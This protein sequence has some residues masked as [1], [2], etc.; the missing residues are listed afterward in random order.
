MIF[1]H[2]N[3]VRPAYYLRRWRYFE[4]NIQELEDKELENAKVL[5]HSLRSLERKYLTIL[6][7]VYYF[8]EQN[9][10]PSALPEK[11]GVS[12]YKFGNMRREAQDELKKE[13]R[14]TI[15]LMGETHRR[16]IHKGRH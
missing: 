7:D 6:T 8:A 9:R 15:E 1:L 4:E 13:M 11:Y 12:I 14:K 5:F 10:G 3:S 16:D 2:Y